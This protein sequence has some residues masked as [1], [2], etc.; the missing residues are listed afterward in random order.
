MIHIKARNSKPLFNIPF[1]DEKPT[2]W[3]ELYLDETI[4]RPQYP[5]QEE[6]YE[7]GE[8][9]IHRVF[10]RWDK[11]Y[12]IRIKRAIES[13]CDVVSMLP[14]MDYVY[15]NGSRVFDVDVQIQWEEEVDCLAGI[16]MTFS[17]RNAIKTL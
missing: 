4:E 7:D 5:V 1:S 14:L 11:Q 16:T 3:I 6:A 9:D 2:I 15:V 17:N 13:T 10:Q 8:G 12:A